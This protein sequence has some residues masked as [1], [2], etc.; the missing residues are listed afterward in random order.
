MLGR[1]EPPSTASTASAASAAK[2][3]LI[4]QLHQLHLHNC[5]YTITLVTS[6][7]NGDLTLRTLVPLF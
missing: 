7:A 3:A 6:V 5:T 2:A 1:F 4:T